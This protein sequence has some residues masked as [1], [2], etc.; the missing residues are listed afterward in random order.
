MNDN[1]IIKLQFWDILFTE[2]NIQSNKKIIDKS[3][4][5]IFVCTYDNKESLKRVIHWHK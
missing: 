5:I 3:D 2:E 4:G 1:Q